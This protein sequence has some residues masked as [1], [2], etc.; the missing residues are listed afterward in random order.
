MFPFQKYDYIPLDKNKR[1]IRL[2]ELHAAQDDPPQIRCS[3]FTTSLDNAP[4][5]TSLSY[6]WGDAS[7]PLTIEL[8][9]ATLSV[10][11]NLHS[12]LR[13]LSQYEKVVRV[14]WVDAMCINQDDIPERNHQIMLMRDIYESARQTI[15]W[16]GEA[17]DDSGLAF[18]LIEAWGNC[19]NDFDGFLQKSPFA[20][21]EKMWDAAN[22]LLQRSWWMRVWVYQEF[23][24]SK[25]VIFVCGPEFM[26]NRTLVLACEAWDEF[27]S[28][29]AV[30]M[31]DPEQ[32]TRLVFFG[33]GQISRLQYQHLMHD[34][35]RTLIQRDQPHEDIAR[36]DLLQLLRMTRDMEA[37]DPRDKLYALLGLDDIR[38]I[39]VHPNYQHSELKVYTDFAVDYIKT[40]ANLEILADAGIG[41]PNVTYSYH[42]GCLIS[43]GLGFSSKERISLHWTIVLLA[44]IDQILE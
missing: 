27:P 30:K 1:E 7:N 33:T 4:E 20:F 19:N 28:S 42:H 23:V 13:Q 2:L 38:D 15:V 10:T 29:D 6:C 35:R 37:T 11:S 18:Q 16:L 41:I 36:M 21:D 8:N 17:A 25:R 43:E 32:L 26:A 14:L 31:V 5:Y 22:K 39:P 12:A 3:I 9:D 44:I 24:L 40:R 34:I